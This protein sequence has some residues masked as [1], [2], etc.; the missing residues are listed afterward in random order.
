MA[1]NLDYNVTGSVCYEN[2]DKNCA[3]YGRLYDWAT[4]MAL[5]VSCNSESCSEQIN[6]K[7]K[8]ICP[9]GWHIP[10]VY[11]L[12]DL[13]NY[14]ESNSGCSGCAGKHLKA[15]KGWS[16]DAYH[17]GQDTYGFSAL[18]GGTYDTILHTF[19]GVGYGGDWWAT[20]DSEFQ[21]THCSM[22]Y[23]FDEAGHGG[24]LKS[25]FSSVRCLKD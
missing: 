21:A 17:D 10:S 1:E 5:D 14:V 12:I 19:S 23:R 7:H 3:K 4:A 18:P 22:S 25:S 9:S 6:A 8:G 11:E 13:F 20:D 16:S 2:N 15:Q 24:M